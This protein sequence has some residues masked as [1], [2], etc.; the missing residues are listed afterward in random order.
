M[1]LKFAINRT[2]APFRDLASFLAL[3]RGAGVEGVEIRNDVAGQEFANG[4]KPAE[5][6]ARVADAGLAIASINALQRFNDWDAARFSEARALIEFAGACG[7][8]GLVLCPV[9]DAADRRGPAQLEADLRRSLRELKP[10]LAD[11]NV[12][13]LVEPL[14][15]PA[16][17]LK[18]KTPAVEAIGDV[19]GFGAFALCHDTFQHFRCGD[20][21]FYPKHTGMLHVSGIV[22]RGVAREA[23]VE[24]DR[25]FVDS[26]DIAG[27]IEQVSILLGQGYGGFISFEP[28]D[29]AVQS[30]EDPE[31]KLVASIAH[32][33]SAVASTRLE[34]AE[35]HSKPPRA[36]AIS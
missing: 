23:L 20:T 29:P 31:P 3:A 24:P 5:L 8:P 14:G 32:I 4:I 11:N 16:S 26:G 12:T 36:S 9:V 10:I 13:G 25:G 27:T 15:M 2:V 35:R 22:R 7:A 17:T 21:T 34:P 28:F 6:A 19:E 33:Y 1:Q 30:L 18:F